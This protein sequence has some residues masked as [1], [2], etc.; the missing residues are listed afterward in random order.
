MTDFIE[1]REISESYS[2]YNEEYSWAEEYSEYYSEDSSSYLMPVF[3]SSSYQFFGEATFYQEASYKG[4][5]AGGILGLVSGAF[6]MIMKLLKGGGGGSSSSSSKGSGKKSSSDKPSSK[7]EPKPNKDVDRTTRDTPVQST[8]PK[9]DE[10]PKEN[11]VTTSDKSKETGADAKGAPKSQTSKK[12]RKQAESKQTTTSLPELEDEEKIVFNVEIIM[13]ALKKFKK[14]NEGV[15]TPYNTEIL[16]LIRDGLFDV[17]IIVRDMVAITKDDLWYVVSSANIKDEAVFRFMENKQKLNETISKLQSES[18][19]L[20]DK[21]LDAKPDVIMDLLEGIDGHIR[22]IEKNCKEGMKICREKRKLEKY[23]KDVSNIDQVYKILNGVL[24]GINVVCKNIQNEFETIRKSLN[25]RQYRTIFLYLN[26][27]IGFGFEYES[28]DKEFYMNKFKR[29]LSKPNPHWMINMLAN[30][31]IS[32]DKISGLLSGAVITDREIDKWNKEHK[33]DFE[34][35]I[36]KARKAEGDMFKDLKKAFPDY[37]RTFEDVENLATRQ[38]DLVAALVNTPIKDVLNKTLAD[39]PT[40]MQ[41]IEFENNLENTISD[42]VNKMQANKSEAKKSNTSQVDDFIKTIQSTMGTLESA[43]EQNVSYEFGK[44]KSG[45]E[46]AVN[47]YQNDHDEDDLINAVHETIRKYVYE[48]D[49]KVG[50]G[51]EAWNKV[52]SWLENIGYKSINAKPG[53]SLNPI[54]TYFRTPIPSATSVKS[55][56][57]TIK[58]VQLQPRALKI[59]IDGETVPF[60]LAGKCTYYVYK[61]STEVKA[62]GKDTEDPNMAKVSDKAYPEKPKSRAIDLN[63]TWDQL[64][65]E[66]QKEREKAW[67]KYNDRRTQVKTNTRKQKESQFA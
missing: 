32:S 6:F 63:Y 9:V 62:S 40:V 46:K 21:V 34:N 12:E 60:K 24:K 14:E 67:S 27:V 29:A 13:N 42:I 65:P 28:D 53:D 37:E 31:M 4:L 66:E 41:L 49:S 30:T 17:H 39:I 55:Q 16:R 56:N 10:V 19:D 25:G 64:T 15:G 58:Q 44:F 22:D 51:T 43:M 48:S 59:K 2:I 1:S 8:A 52:E 23:K 35:R 47:E 26:G 20:E 54:R 5:I 45:F 61:D 38:L 7:S 11:P 50:I 3:E 57:M 36:K 18:K 33:Q